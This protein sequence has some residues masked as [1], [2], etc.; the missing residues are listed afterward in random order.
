[1][2]IT[3]KLGLM[4][5]LSII[6]SIGAQNIFV[7][8]QAIRNEYAY[9]AALICFMC[10]LIMILL[11]VTGVSAV[12]MELPFLKTALLILGVGF[13]LRYGIAALLR[14][15][16]GDV[17]LHD[18]TLARDGNSVVK[19]LSK[20]ILIGLS[21][22]FLNPQ[23]ILDTIVIIGGSANQY[24]AEEKYLFI[25]GAIMASFIWFFSLTILTKCFA[26][27]LT[28]NVVWRGLEFLS[29]GLMLAIAIQFMRAILSESLW[30]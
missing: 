28:N 15:L 5:G 22:S 10:D 14:G 9:L 24:V 30:I 19:S 23:A 3:L 29:G 7:I 13:L 12:L 25:T 8:Q 11:G 6:I 4:L 17:V 2:F 16:R 21:F 27:K 18:L 20:V 1:M 26:T